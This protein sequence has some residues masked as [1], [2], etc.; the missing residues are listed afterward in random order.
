MENSLKIIKLDS[1]PSRVIIVVIAVA[2]LTLTYFSAKW[3]FA[4]GVAPTFDRTQP[5]SPMVANWLTEVAPG[6]PSVRLAAAVTFERTFDMN[7]LDRSMR[8]YS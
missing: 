7:D 8:E 4:N 6:D 3:H 1:T 2:C 5:E